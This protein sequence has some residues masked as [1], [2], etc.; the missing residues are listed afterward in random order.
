MRRA[1]LDCGAISDGSRCELHRKARHTNRYGRGWQRFAR[2]RIA[3]YRA[4]HGDVC[5]GWQ[6]PPHPIDPQEWTVDHDVGQPMCRSCNSRK[7]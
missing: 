7:Q 3:N 4:V 1:C 6:R 2:M 5:P